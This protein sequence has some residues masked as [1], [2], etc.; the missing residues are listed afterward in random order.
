MA[1]SRRAVELAPDE[2]HAHVSRG[3]SVSL[4][5]DYDEAQ[6]EFE[7]AIRLEPA[8]FDA[9]YIYA[10]VCYEQ[11][12]LEKALEL[13]EQS[14]RI[15][16]DDYQAAC[17][18]TT[19]LA[20]LKRGSECEVMG[21]HALDRITKHLE[22]YPQDG[23]ALYMGAIV[24]V[25]HGEKQRGLEWAERALAAD[26][27]EP[28]SGTTSPAPTLSWGKSKRPLTAWNARLIWVVLGWRGAKT[29]QT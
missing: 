5:K 9:H 7:A 19:V 8:S 10:R 1:A 29:T 14:A 16:L 21:R 20:G 6:N 4:N 3:L 24:S 22:L 11:G 28:S 15:N 17:L 25:H 12:K 2:A 13:F 18:A 26:P 27:N 23:R